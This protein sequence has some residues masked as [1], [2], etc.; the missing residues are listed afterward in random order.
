MTEIPAAE[1]LKTLP[2]RVSD[3]VKPS[4]HSWP[5]RLALVEPGG[6]WTYAQLGTVVAQTAVMLREIGVRPGDRVMIL[7]ENCRAFVAIFLALTEVDAWPVLVNARLSAREVDQIREHCGPRRVLYMVAV[8]PQAMKHA[9]RH[10]AEIREMGELGLVGIGALDEQVQSAPVEKVTANNVAALIYTSGSTGLPKGVMLSNRNILY[11]AAIS[12]QVRSLTP[13]DRLLGVLPMSHA[14]GLSVVTLGTLISGGTLYIFPRFDPVAVTASLARDGI[15]ILLGAPSLFAILIDYAKLKGFHALTFPAL[16]VISSSGAP[17]SAALKTQVEVL[18][19]MVLHNGYGVTECSPTIALTRLETPRKDTSVGPI[20]PGMQIRLVDREGK[21]VANGDVGELHVRGPNIMTGYY[22]A[23]EQTQSAIDVDGW[24]NTRDLARVEEEHLFIVGRTKELIV[25]F[26]FNV[27]PAEVEAV[28][29]AHPSVARSAVI[30]Q[31]VE[32]E[33]E[34]IAFVELQ[35]GS[36]TT[37]EEIGKHA[38]N[39]LAPYKQP[40]RILF[41]KE[42]PLTPTGKP[43]KDELA[44]LLARNPQTQ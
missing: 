20:F 23:L 41:L 14:V 10:A 29:N 25:R 24:F 26:G 43:K 39:N 16:R 12:A 8:S 31:L 27:Y 42:I 40:S 28:F 1:I 38:A 21:R 35:P 11:M 3:I 30:G 22:R 17:L 33:E 32:G 7:V 4:K 18:F 36:S 15:T 13:E 44:K 37:S 34:V 19:G 9:K 6:R 2:A 5:D